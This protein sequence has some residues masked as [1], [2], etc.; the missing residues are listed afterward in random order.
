MLSETQKEGLHLVH[1]YQVPGHHLLLPHTVNQ[2]VIPQPNIYEVFVLNLLMC[3]GVLAPVLH[4]DHLRAGL[5]L[6]PH[7]QPIPSSDVVTILQLRSLFHSIVLA[8]P[9]FTIILSLNQFL[10]SITALS[11]SSPQSDH[12]LPASYRQI[13]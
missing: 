8:F 5:I 6:H 2:E 11:S 7:H 9:M 13:H 12:V 4:I 1:P 10:S 3:H